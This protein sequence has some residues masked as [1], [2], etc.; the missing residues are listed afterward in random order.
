MRTF[1]SALLALVSL[2][3][4]GTALALPQGRVLPLSGTA[5]SQ[6]HTSNVTAGG[7][8]LA[9][10]DFNS[11]AG[12]DSVWTEN[13]PQGDA[14]FRIDGAGSGDAYLEIEIPGGSEHQSFGS[15]TA[16]YLTQAVSNDDFEVELAF[17]SLPA[18]GQLIGLMVLQDSSRWVRFDLYGF[19]SSVFLY[20]GVTKN[21]N[22]SNR[23]NSPVTFAPGEA[24][25][26]V[27]RQGSSWTCDISSGGGPYVNKAS[28][29]FNL[30]VGQVGPYAG[31]FGSFPPYV[32]RFDYAFDSGFPVAAE[33]AA[34]CSGTGTLNVQTSGPGQ[35]T[36]NPPGGI[37]PSGTS[38]TLTAVPDAGSV[39][40]GWSGALSGTATSETLVVNGDLTV[41]AAF[42]DGV[43]DPPTDPILSAISASAAA[44]SAVITWNTDLAS[45]SRVDYGVSPAY[46]QSEQSAAAV[47]AHSLSIDGLEP[48]TTYHF[49]V[50]ST[51]AAGGAASSGDFVFTTLAEAEGDLASDDFNTCGGSLQPFW[52]LTDS[53][54]DGMVALLGGGTDDAL[55]NISVPGGSEHRAWNSLNVPFLGQPVPDGDFLIRT[56]LEFAPGNSQTAG[57]LVVEDDA[58]WI[59]FDLTG[60]NGSLQAYAGVTGGGQT[61]GKTNQTIAGGEPVWM[62]LERVGNK[63]K[64]WVSYDGSNYSL[65]KA[66]RRDIVMTRVG[67]YAGNSGSS[68]AYTAQFDFFENADQPILIE[69]GPVSG[70]G[71]PATLD[72]TIAGAGSVL[73]SPDQP[74]YSCSEVVTLTAVP[75]AGQLFDGWSGDLAGSSNPITIAVSQDRAVTATF[76]GDGGGGDPPP[77]ISGISINAGT[78]MAQVVWDTDLAADSR[79]DW[80]IGGVPAGTVSSPAFVT[81]HDLVLM[82]LTPSTTYDLTLQSSTP[83]GQQ[84]SATG[85]TFTT[86]GGPGGSTIS[87]DDFQTCTG[88]GAPWIFTNS[89]AGD[90]AASIEQTGSDAVLRITAP[91]GVERQAFGTITAPYVTQ[92]VAD[93]DIELEAKFLTR[94]QAGFAIQGIL[95]LGNAGRWIRFDTYGTGSTTRWY[96]GRTV[97]G[98]TAQVAEGALP[99]L[100]EPMWIQVAR[101]GNDWTYR[102]SVDGVSFTD[103]ASF[104]FAMELDRIGPYAGS[105]SGSSSPGFVSEVDY[106]FDTADPI[107]PEDGAGTGSYTV[108]VT[109][110]GGGSVTLNPDQATYSCGDVVTLTAQANSGNGFDFWSGDAS[111][112]TNPLDIVVGANTQITANFVPVGSGPVISGLSVNAGVDAAT[113]SW[114]T[115]IP[116]S[117]RVDY[118]TTT[119]YGQFEQSAALVTSHS[120]SLSGL[121]A[122]TTYQ[123]QVSSTSATGTSASPNSNFTTVPSTNVASDDFNEPNLDLGLWTFTDPAGLAELRMVGSGTQDAG[124]EIQ[125]PPGVPYTPFGTNN[126]ARITQPA[127]DTDLSMT[128]KFESEISTINSST[129]VF[130]EADENNWVR[131]DFFYDGQDLNLFSSSFTNG[132]AGDLRNTVVQAGPWPAG[133]PLYL[134][135]SRGGVIWSADY[136]FDGVNFLTGNSF[137]QSLAVQRAGLLCGNDSSDPQGH[138]V[139]ADWFIDTAAPIANEDPAPGADGVDPFLYSASATVLGPNAAELRWRTDEL[140]TGSVAW[141]LDTTYASGSANSNTPAYEHTILVTGLVP[142]A[143][144]HFQAMAEDAANNTALSA[145]TTFLTP[146]PPA[147]GEPAVDFWYGGSDP[148]TGTNILPF[149]QIGDAQAQVNVIGRITDGDE[150]RVALTVTLQYRLNGGPLQDAA[151]GDDRTINYEPWRLADEGDFNIELFPSE[152]VNVPLLLGVHRNV[153]EIVASDDDGNVTIRP[154]FIDYTPGVDWDPNTSI[155]WSNVLAGGGDISTVSQV[156]DGR[157]GVETLPSLGTV[158]RTDPAHQGYDRLVALGEAGGP[159]G[160]DNYEALVPLTV[161][162]LDPQGFTTGTGSHAMGFILR[163]GGHTENGPYP[164]PL[165]GLYPVGALWLYRWF[166]SNERWQLWI[167]EN[168][169][170]I[171]QQG[172]NI[173]IGTTYI[174]R[175]RCESQLGGGT[176]Y[177]IKFWEEGTPEP[178]GWNFTYT[179]NPGDPPTG[180]FAFFAHH[181]DV[182]I[183]DVSITQL[184]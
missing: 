156:V 46:G 142:G 101:S 178:A 87:S 182:A 2:L 112:N 153:L 43:P 140:T 134:R 10:D 25:M 71:T 131:F 54:G 149:G 176:F 117:S 145:D 166:P 55:L 129:G 90:G 42:G 132:N 127:A 59:R 67:L 99:A 100:G 172:G 108:D 33:D 53:P 137:F 169:Q 163:W 128:V 27:R 115:D 8:Y 31:N 97:N 56:R 123:F 113:I 94:P 107:V 79:A 154:C 119:S 23:A 13:D 158:L 20:S 29:S 60:N 7:G 88:L 152:L 161:L 30:A 171:N 116:A 83:A 74:T 95:A 69:D 111:G 36:L 130:L 19:G 159:G 48:E 12:I 103:L 93:G 104:T 4:S 32:A 35:V 168:E 114:T 75:A 16:P 110:A 173:A 86:G 6:G 14:I 139:R 1:V 167:N 45:D 184:P 72:V 109:V 73:R 124:V 164:Q 136:S 3:A 179:T 78:D 121:D 68:P 160:W 92:S 9:S 18:D 63:F 148:I 144:Y 84:A 106:V 91:A 126:S 82:G 155:S 21:G 38:V 40:E 146:G 81:D 52:V 15:L 141:G 64:W 39:F 175:L 138:T 47:T 41:G 135:V 174:Y 105:A 125:I 37:Y 77:V 22:T 34:T 151:I 143:T 61:S 5:A 157:W 177:A 11:C 49:Q 66:F 80:S 122:G 183:G 70:S 26:R 85:L 65:L 50:S 58:N 57:F 118:G 102:Y 165:H 62:Q 96:V 147:F 28:Y 44:R 98:N 51:T 162:E 89:P 17:E 180:S 150:D 76:V 170:I 24:R 120:V 181:A 133:T